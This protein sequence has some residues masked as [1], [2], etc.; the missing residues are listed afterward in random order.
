MERLSFLDKLAVLGSNILAHPIFILLLLSPIV[1]FVLNKKITRKIV[2]AIYVLILAIVL[3]VGNSTIFELLDNLIDGIFMTVYFP[4]FV[5]LFVVV[6]AS[7]IIALITF[8][9]KKMFKANK[10]IN[11]TGFAIVQ[12]MFCLVFAAFLPPPVRR[13]GTI[14]GFVCDFAGCP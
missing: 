6:V 5:T 4:N 2:I 9:K 13:P 7:A 10:I 14:G 8:L 11:I 12:T 1:I 3:F